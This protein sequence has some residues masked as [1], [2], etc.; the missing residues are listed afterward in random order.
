MPLQKN[1]IFMED[2]S[3]A[4]MVLSIVRLLAPV[5]QAMLADN[6][7]VHL[8]HLI[9]S[10]T[11]FL[12]EWIHNGVSSKKNKIKLFIGSRISCF[13][14]EMLIYNAEML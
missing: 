12:N 9:V 10:V 7:Q 11:V 14:S 1:G 5:Y 13:P 4:A 8:I 2:S 6:M 3:T